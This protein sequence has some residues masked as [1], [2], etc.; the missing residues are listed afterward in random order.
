MPAFDV[1]KSDIPL[2]SGAEGALKI[3]L[4]YSVGASAGYEIKGT[5]SIKI[6]EIALSEHYAL[7][8]VGKL[9]VSGQVSGRF[10]VDVSKGTQDWRPSVP[11]P[12]VNRTGLLE[13]FA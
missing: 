4:K 12:N 9:T 2:W 10:S 3:A 6:S 11:R 7:S 8:V 13:L 1:R 5:K